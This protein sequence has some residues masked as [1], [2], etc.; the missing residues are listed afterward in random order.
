MA[1]FKLAYLIY[2]ACSVVAASRDAISGVQRQSRQ[3]SRR[4]GSDCNSNEQEPH[5]PLP[6]LVMCVKAQTQAMYANSVNNRKCYVFVNDHRAFS[7]PAVRLQAA[8]NCDLSVGAIK[9]A[10]RA[11]LWCNKR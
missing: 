2:M 7:E 6:S 3:Q 8:L 11:H 4:H 10:L 5:L 1:A 9:T